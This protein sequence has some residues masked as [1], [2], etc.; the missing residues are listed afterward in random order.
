MLS[1]TSDQIHI[2][3]RISSPSKYSAVSK[4]VNPI[5]K[6]KY[7]ACIGLVNVLLS[8]RV[9]NKMTEEQCSLQKAMVVMMEKTAKLKIPTKLPSLTQRKSG[10]LLD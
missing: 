7:L 5:I 10:L 8:R 4:R 3:A 2:I 9:C 6:Q 1:I